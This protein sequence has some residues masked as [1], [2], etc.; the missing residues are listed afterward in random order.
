LNKNLKI[1]FTGMKKS[2]LL[3]CMFSLAIAASSQKTRVNLYANYVFDDKFDSYYD[4]Y[5]YYN[6]KVDG[7]FQGGVGIERM[8][9]SH[10]CV[11]LMWLHQ[12]T[13]APTTYLAGAT[14]QVKNENFKLNIDYVLI[15]GDGHFPAPSGKV[16]GYAGI[17]LGMAFL[18]AENPSNGNHN[19]ASKFA[20][21]T[22]LGCNVW[23]NGKLGIKLQAQLMSIAQGAGGGL[24]FG[25]GGAGVGV[26]TY[27]TMYQFGLGGGLTFRLGH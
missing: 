14:S 22:R 11:E 20:W 25:T 24:Y 8:L 23:A 6:G 19:T 1:K 26:S 4:T 16:D 17:F 5:N 9:Q 21:G 13:H 2:F 7:G 18:G 15:G 27:S 10:Y 12:S 3:I